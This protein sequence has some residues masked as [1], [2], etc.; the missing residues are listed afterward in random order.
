M[1]KRILLFLILL[2]TIL[3]GYGHPLPFTSHAQDAGRTLTPFAAVGGNLNSE[4]FTEVWTLEGQR[5]QP[6]SLVV[7][8]TS[9]NLNPTVSVLSSSG[10]VLVANDDTRLNDFTAPHRKFHSTG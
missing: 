4:T 10:V 9:G 5:G 6:I 3:A 8:A 1:V 2:V 7:R